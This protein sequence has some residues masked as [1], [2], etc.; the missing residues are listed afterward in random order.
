MAYGGGYFT[1]YTKKMPGTYVNFSSALKASSVLSDRGIV[2]FGDSLTWG[3]SGVTTLSLSDLDT[4]QPILG[5]SQ[6][7]DEMLKVREIF[8]HATKLH[9]YRLDNGGTKAS[10]TYATAKYAGTRGNAITI[11]IASDPEHENKF[12]VYTALDG[13]IV[14]TQDNIGAITDLEA[15]AYVDW[16][17]NSELS[18][19][20][21]LVLSSGLNLSN[22]ANGTGAVKASNSLAEAKYAGTWG[23][24]I[25]IAVAE[26]TEH[27][28]KFVVSTKFG[29]T[30]VDSQD[31]IEAVTDL[32]ANSY[33]DWKTTQ[34]S[35]SE[36]V[37]DYMISD[38]PDP[39]N[40]TNKL[41]VPDTIPQDKVLLTTITHN[42]DGKYTIG[43]FFE[44]DYASV[45]TG[46]YIYK[47]YFL[48]NEATQGCIE[49]VA[50][51]NQDMLNE[52]YGVTYVRGRYNP[53]AE[54]GQWTGGTWNYKISDTAVTSYTK[55]ECKLIVSEYPDSNSEITLTEAQALNEY[56]QVGLY[57]YRS[58]FGH[59]ADISSLSV[60]NYL[61]LSAG[62]N[63]TDGV[64]AS[65]IYANA[66]Y[67]GVFGNALSIVIAEDTDHAG[68]FVVSTK[69]GN[70]VVDTQSNIG[71]ISDLEDNDYIEWEINI[72]NSST[73]G[74]ALS[75]NAGTP[76]TGGTNGTV[77]GQS[78]QNMLDTAENYSFNILAYDGTDTTTKALFKA[79]TQRM[80]E[81]I[82]ANFQTVLYNYSAD[83]E[84]IINVKNSSDLVPWIAG[85]EAGCAVNASIENMTYDGEKTVSA[86]Y[87]QT[88]LIM[89]MESGELV[90]HK[91]EDDYKVLKDINSLTTFTTL[92]GKKFGEN[93]TIR[94][95]DQIG[96]DVAVMFN[97]QIMGKV[98]N[99]SEG[100]LYVWDKIND[101]MQAL[102]TQRA[103]SNYDSSDLRVFEI[104]G[105][106]SAIGAEIKYTPLNILNKLYLTCIVA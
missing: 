21:G 52:K 3:A 12:V 56:A 15:N 16:K 6:N 73:A 38:Y 22:G 81:E 79:F 48:Y 84:G 14:D 39:F 45:A 86:N 99:D 103:I 53:D 89:S 63:G 36:L 82:G 83:Y 30:V 76:L 41:I 97:T 93:T 33:V 47:Y 80:R 55:A 91:V 51:E 67:E 37:Y 20:V 2:F 88:Q 92:K 66:K 90:F 28:G 11:I 62:A 31:N 102:A 95:N 96:N 19:N 74:I 4:L 68:K 72:E 42:L 94:V 40:D 24:S 5:Y 106:S 13:V 64:K 75:L 59:S 101:I 32:V 8:K 43:K 17:T 25:S 69:F 105:D 87:T 58:Q 35:S 100:R 61:S 71:S 23:N 104:D 85:A 18:E 49:V 77:T 44:N 10:N 57:L 9:L 98:Q 27:T 26:D 50:D 34:G 78:Y 7:A 54:I 1:T 46:K 60:M 29:D 65:N 70:T